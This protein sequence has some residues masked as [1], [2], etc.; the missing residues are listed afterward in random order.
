MSNHLRTRQNVLGAPVSEIE[1]RL[2]AVASAFGIA[3]LKEN[4]DHPLQKLWNRTD[5]LATNE[6]VWFGDAILS[7]QSVDRKW[8]ARELDKVKNETANNRKGAA[9]EIIGLGIFAK[10][11]RVVPSAGN[12]P[13]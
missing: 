5:Y 4:R 8:T 10:R 2:E 6:L 13:G 12:N 9:F 7:M 1:E 11:L 3:W